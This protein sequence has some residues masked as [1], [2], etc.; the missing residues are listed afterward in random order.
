VESIGEVLKNRRTE[1]GLG[2]AEV[3]EATKIM[4]QN[5]AALEEDRF[6]AFPNRVYARAFLRDYANFLGLDSGA[7]LQ[8]YEAEWAAPVV[9]PP[10]RRSMRPAWVA[11]I[12]I[13]ILG[14]AGGG[15][16]YYYLTQVRGKR[17]PVRQVSV[18]PTGNYAPQTPPVPPVAPPGPTVPPTGAQPT[19]AQ[20]T[21]AAPPVGVPPKPGV[22]EVKLHTL[23]QPVWVHVIVN[24]RN[25][26]ESTLAPDSTATFAGK[27]IF[28]KTGKANY[29]DVTVNGK[30][31]GV[32]GPADRIVRR[33][34]PEPSSVP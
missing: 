12:T 1:R 31:L 11:A 10:P 24:G 22:V 7:L 19:G 14:G 16:Y 17:P 2:L 5:L 13:V 30:G 6:D 28:V 9:V 15:A 29:L 26:Y 23:G 21:G 32:F 34:F 25:E 3:H 33:V 27:K 18:P 4:M 8:R 20:P